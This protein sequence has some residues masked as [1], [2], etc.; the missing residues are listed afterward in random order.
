MPTKSLVVY[1]EIQQILGSYSW[2]IPMSSL[3]CLERGYLQEFE[4][5]PDYNFLGVN[6]IEEL[7]DKMRDKGMVLFLQERKKT[8]VMCAHTVKTKQKVVKRNVQELLDEY[9]GEIPLMSFEVLYMDKFK[10]KLDYHFFGLKDFDMSCLSCVRI[11]YQLEFKRSLDYEFL[12]VKDIEELLGEMRNKGIVLFYENPESK[13]T[14]V[15]FVRHV[16]YSRKLLKRNVQELLDKY[17][18]EIPLSSFEG[19]YEDKFMVK[20]NY[21]L[22]GLKDFDHLCKV[23]SLVVDLAN[24]GEEVIKAGEIYNLRKRK[25]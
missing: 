4:R 25:K 18:G 16:G 13:K 5:L 1:R 20:L 22:C 23:L 8:Y 11:S 15:M 17:D 24:S 3:S 9:G 12:G 2:G 6:N 19:I 10:G 7:L 14:Y 21:Y